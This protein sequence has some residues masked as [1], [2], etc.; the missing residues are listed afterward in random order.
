MTWRRTN[1]Y[2]QKDPPGKAKE[3]GRLGA[4]EVIVS[5]I[6]RSD[7]E[8]SGLRGREEPVRVGAGV[9]VEAHDRAPADPFGQ[10]GGRARDIDRGEHAP[11]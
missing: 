1:N 3:A 11:L 6:A 5:Q 4:G 10:G 9:E 7:G 2:I 8:C